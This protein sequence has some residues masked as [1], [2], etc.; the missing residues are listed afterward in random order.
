MC[1]H[2]SWFS[3]GFHYLISRY[4]NVNHFFV[5]PTDMYSSS[6]TPYS[7]TFTTFVVG[8]FDRAWRG[9]GSP[10]RGGARLGLQRL[11]L[12]YRAFLPSTHVSPAGYCSLPTTTSHVKTL[13]PLRYNGLSMFW[14]WFLNLDLSDKSK[15]VFVLN[16]LILFT[17]F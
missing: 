8:C 2:K 17:I 6:N 7:L 5:W 16:V 3:L 1:F 15:N 12:C 9:R 4:K 13:N 11:S 14:I 10:R